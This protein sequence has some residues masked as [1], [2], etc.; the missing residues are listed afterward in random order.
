MEKRVRMA[1]K[2]KIDIM[3]YLDQ[4][5][6]IAI[7]QGTKDKLLER[8]RFILKEDPD[9]LITL[10]ECCEILFLLKHI[11]TLT[12]SRDHLY[13]VLTSIEDCI[14]SGINAYEETQRTKQKRHTTPVISFDQ[15]L[16]LN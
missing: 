3:K 13:G 5:Y 7:K 2:T 15:D 8:L 4:S 11:K 9:R 10:R 14:V 6:V 12:S 16:G 1:K